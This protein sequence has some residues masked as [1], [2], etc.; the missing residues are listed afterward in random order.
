M[1]VVHQRLPVCSGRSR[2]ER[3]GGPH[4]QHQPGR[5]SP[6]TL[7]E[8]HDLA[9]GQLDGVRLPAVAEGHEAVRL[10]PE[11]QLGV[12]QALHQL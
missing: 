10:D 1:T 6:S 4:S 8:P 12:E 9:T 11:R 7:A 2:L 3:P 5:T